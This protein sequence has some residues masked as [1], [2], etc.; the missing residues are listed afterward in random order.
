MKQFSK[1]ISKL[2]GFKLCRR[3]ASKPLGLWKGSLKILKIC[4][5]SKNIMVSGCLHCNIG[6]VC[7]KSQTN[8]EDPPC[9]IFTFLSCSLRFTNTKH[10]IWDFLHI[11]RMLHEEFYT[12]DFIPCSLLANLRTDHLKLDTLTNKLR[13]QHLLLNSCLI[14]QGC[15]RNLNRNTNTS[16]CILL[17]LKLTKWLLTLNQIRFWC[18]AYFFKVIFLF[19]TH[20]PDVWFFS[21]CVI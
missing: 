2:C 16:L 15:L 11:L 19:S 8:R 10:V 3:A 5:L 21:Y 1:E 18:I 13:F 4:V 12:S 9:I 14:P 6:W 20:F 7:L 17:N